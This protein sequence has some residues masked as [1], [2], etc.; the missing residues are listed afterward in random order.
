MDE[1]KDLEVVLEKLNT[2]IEKYAKAIDFEKYKEIVNFKLSEL[3]DDIIANLDCNEKGIYF[4]EIKKS[5]SIKTI[6]EWKKNFA[7]KWEEES[8]CKSP[9]IISK[10]VR[11]I[12]ELEEWIPF[13]LGK[14]ENIQKRIKEHLSLRADSTTYALKLSSRNNLSNET[15]RIKIFKIDT[16]YY[17]LVMG[18]IEYILREKLNPIVGKQ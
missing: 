7:E 13:Y 4:F 14:S 15:F 3:N 10:R 18:K 9:K 17:D 11:K 16:K 2:K 6:E 1:F 12:K 5:D 8:T